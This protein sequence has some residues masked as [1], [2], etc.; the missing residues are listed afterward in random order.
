M[1]GA[2]LRRWLR[3][4]DCPEVIRQFKALFDKALCTDKVK[5]DS[6]D[7]DAAVWRL[8]E[9]AHFTHKGVTYSRAST[10]LG[11]SLISY[12]PCSVSSKPV[13]GSIQKIS[14][15]GK[16]VYFT[17]RRQA[18]LPANKHDPFLRY[19]AFPASVY[20]SHMS[21]DAV[22]TITVSL[23]LSHVAR[24]EFSNDR[25]VIINLSRVCRTF[26]IK[27]FLTNSQV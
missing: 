19:P 20:S 9:V 12:Y 16:S 27:L 26:H 4:P 18:P 22:D 24:F 7:D 5:Q 8:P 13:I 10:H 21:N 14:S 11:N 17:V 15:S 25:A 2:N 1:R 6:S 23:V 3:R